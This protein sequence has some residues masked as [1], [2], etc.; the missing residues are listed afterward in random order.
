MTENTTESTVQSLDEVLE[1][2]TFGRE[3]VTN[4]WI[5]K[6]TG[7]I[8]LVSCSWLIYDQLVRRKDQSMNIGKHIV[9]L[10][11]ACDIITSLSLFIL[12]S[13]MVPKGY[14]WGAVGNEATCTAQ[15]FIFTTFSNASATYNAMLSIYFLLQVRYSWAQ[16]RFQ[17]M[18][19]RFVF[20]VLPVAWSFPLHIWGVVDNVY[21]MEL[22]PSQVG[23]HF[24]FAPVACAEFPEIGGECKTVT[25]TFTLLYY[26]TG[27][28]V[29]SIVMLIT[30]VSM[31]LLWKFIHATDEVQAQW[32]ARNNTGNGNGYDRS[33]LAAKVGFLFCAAYF[34]AQICFIICLILYFTVGSFPD[35]L[36]LITT[37]LLSL[38]GFFNVLVYAYRQSLSK[39]RTNSSSAKNSKSKTANKSAESVDVGA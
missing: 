38:Q 34:V 6:V 39:N 1:G 24:W 7:L 16:S 15:G 3:F 10:M 35:W 37:F 8:T 13:S 5:F 25:N 36:L 9:V 19:I 12:G 26:L 28:A 29:P 20:L 18:W 23:C 14:S 32:R 33:M 27:M 4:Q 21:G 31:F 11:S 22:R 30:I 2:V 17:T